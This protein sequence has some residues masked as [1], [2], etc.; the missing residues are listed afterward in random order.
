MALRNR[1]AL[2]SSRR[3][4]AAVGPDYALGAIIPNPRG[5]EL[6][7]DYWQP[8]LYAEL[9]AIYDVFVFMVYLTYR[10][11]GRPYVARRDREQDDPAHRDRPPGRPGPPH[12]R[13]GP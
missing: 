10:G 12:R 1:R 4:R 6:R 8:F 13:P 3:L 11:D 7:R 9:A 2:D 5:M